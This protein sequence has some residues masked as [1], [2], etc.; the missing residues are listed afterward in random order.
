MLWTIVGSTSC[1]KTHELAKILNDKKYGLLDTY[2]TNI[3]IFSENVY[4]D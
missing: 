2:N 4:T 3:Y 1:G